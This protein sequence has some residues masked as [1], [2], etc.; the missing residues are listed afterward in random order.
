ML[1]S[2]DFQ[3]VSAKVVSPSKIRNRN[4]IKNVEFNSVNCSDSNSEETEN[5]GFAKLGNGNKKWR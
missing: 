1:R 3:F 5:G 4:N 2:I